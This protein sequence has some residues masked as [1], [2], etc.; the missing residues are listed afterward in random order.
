MCRGR[1]AADLTA[2]DTL[3]FPVVQQCASATDRWIEI[4]AAGQDPEALEL[5]APA[6]KL[7]PASG[8]DDD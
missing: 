1:L 3:Y 2:G 5:P 8:G 4:P 6:L 7:L